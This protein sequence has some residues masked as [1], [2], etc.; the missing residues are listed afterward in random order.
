MKAGGAS[1]SPGERQ[2]MTTSFRTTLRKLQPRSAWQAAAPLKARTGERANRLPRSS[3]VIF[4]Q[5]NSAFPRRQEL[6]G[7]PSRLQIVQRR[8]SSEVVGCTG[9]DLFC[10]G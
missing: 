4:R 7:G 6:R 10:R 2:S 1:N 3:A 5:V 9:Y 8:G